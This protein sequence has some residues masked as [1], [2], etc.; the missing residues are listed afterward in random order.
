MKESDIG[1]NPG[2]ISIIVPCYNGALFLSRLLD[3]IC[4]QTYT[5]I[6]LIFVND[7]SV[8]KTKDVFDSYIPLFQKIGI[9]YIYIEQRNS[10]QASAVNTALPYVQGEYLMWIDADDYLVENHIEKKVDCLNKHRDVS[11]VCCR[12]AKVVENNV[13]RVAGYLNNS[14]VAGREE[15][16]FENIL[17]ERAHCTPGLYMVRTKALLNVLPNKKI[18]P[19]NVG[20]NLQLLLPA[21]YKYKT[22]FM[23]EILFYYVMRR[24]SHSHNIHGIM[25]WC[26]RF[27]AVRELKI[28]VLHEMEGILPTDYMNLLCRVVC[29]QELY[30][31]ID[32]ILGS[33][34][35]EDNGCIE[36]EIVRLYRNFSGFDNGRQY[37]IWGFYDKSVRLK[38]Y[39]KRY[40]GIAV[41]GFIDS[42]CSKWN[43]VDVISPNNIN[44]EK[45]YL[46][47]M[48]CN[49]TDIT[50]K[51]YSHGFRMKQDVYYPIFEIDEILNNY[52]I[53]HGGNDRNEEGRN[54]N[55]SFCG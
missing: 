43:G 34:Y 19:S 2:L 35:E 21:S 39:L 55:I 53:N 14:C 17:L 36:E 38:E 51:L 40:A 13:G 11:I 54:C 15:M 42:D 47:I 46:I 32:M 10:G 18:Y 45:M 44:V 23:N 31:K 16:L 20:Q 26:K 9:K 41:K 27:Q 6:Q 52:R 25:E 3:S 33:S 49:H 1:I 4:K 24:D 37:W 8:D 29:I 7:G 5:Y 22:Y 12:G 30:Q 50:E 48:L 28:H